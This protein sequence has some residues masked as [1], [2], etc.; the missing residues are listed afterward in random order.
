MRKLFAIPCLFLILC[1][2][3]VNASADTFTLVGSSGVTTTNGTIVGP[4]SGLLNSTSLMVVCN[5]YNH[6]VDFGQTWE[7][8]VRTFDQLSGSAL[9]QYQQAAWLTTQFAL[10]PTSSWGDIQF[11]VWRVFTNDPALIT[12]GSDFWLA[13]AMSQ[14]FS[15]FDFGAFRILT[16]TGADGQEMITVIP[17]PAT[18][19]LLGTGLTAVAA[20]VRRRR[21][22][23]AAK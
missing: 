22:A 14:D 18:L 5:D 16:P 19:L 11:A 10:N 9:A 4:L 23:A 12:A 7:V 13:Q 2:A 1:C 6:H 20:G 17:E 8:Q 15:N 21:R 3:S